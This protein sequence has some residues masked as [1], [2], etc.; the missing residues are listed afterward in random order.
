MNTFTVTGRIGH[1]EHKDTRVGPML[2]LSVY[3]TYYAQAKNG[4]QRGDKQSQIWNC[5]VGPAMAGRM[6]RFLTKGTFVV[7]IGH[8]KLE[9]YHSKKYDCPM[10]AVDVLAQRIDFFN[11]ASPAH[12]NKPPEHDESVVP[13]DEQDR[14]EDAFADDDIPF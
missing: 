6:A 5:T 7:I 8:L 4:E 12:R 11:L 14:E 2:K 10:T 13:Y 9:K 3:D 1:V